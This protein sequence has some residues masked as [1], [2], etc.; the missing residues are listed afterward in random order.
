M[1]QKAVEPKW[2]E[3]LSRPGFFGAFTIFW[4]IKWVVFPPNWVP[5]HREHLI[6][7]C[8]LAAALLCLPL[9]LL[10][11]RRSFRKFQERMVAL[12]ADQEDMGLLAKS[13]GSVLTGCY[14]A[15]YF[16]VLALSLPR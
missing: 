10:S 4:V 8:L 14:F 9:P 13:V 3:V 15:L 6:N 11:L 1:A 5:T 2:R 7:L 16:C 12:G